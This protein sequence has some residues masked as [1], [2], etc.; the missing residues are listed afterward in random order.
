MLTPQRR[1][2]NCLSFLALIICLT[3]DHPA[4]CPSN[5]VEG[6]DPSLLPTNPSGSCVSQACIKMML[7]AHQTPFAT[8]RFPFPTAVLTQGPNES[9][10]FS[11]TIEF[12]L[13]CLNLFIF[14]LLLQEMGFNNNF[15][16]HICSINFVVCC[17]SCIFIQEDI[18]KSS[19]FLHLHTPTVGT[20][21]VIY[22]VNI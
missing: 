7:Q 3:S 15:T 1:R 16:G 9:L 21:T 18:L 13:G 11:F 8:Q 4:T 6:C 5:V 12:S 19:K 14:L 17:F 20:Y 22:S 2:T 10:E